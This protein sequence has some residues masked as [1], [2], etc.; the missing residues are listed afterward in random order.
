MRI[1]I[2]LPVRD[3]NAILRKGQPDKVV[4][5]ICAA[6]ARGEVSHMGLPKLGQRDN[7]KLLIV[8]VT[9]EKFLE[10]YDETLASGKQLSLR[11]IVHYVIE[12]EL[13]ND[14]VGEEDADE[15][16]YFIVNKFIN[17]G[18]RIATK[19]PKARS[20]IM[21]VILQL[22]NMFKETYEREQITDETTDRE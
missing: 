1:R 12:M 15:N 2:W 8:N 19:V 17:L 9:D 10:L 18:V 22:Q 20:S 4:N 7:D 16:T 6:V 13:L 3:Y 11:R 5:S 21:A 14:I